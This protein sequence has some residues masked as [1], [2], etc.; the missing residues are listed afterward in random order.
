V[1]GAALKARKTTRAIYLGDVYYMDGIWV[2]YFLNQT[3]VWVYLDLYPF[4][5]ICVKD[6]F[7]NLS[8]LRSHLEH[9][10]SR[11]KIISTERISDYF[12]RR[13]ESPAEVIDYYQASL[14]EEILTPEAAPNRLYCIVYVHSFTD[15]QMERGYDGFKSVYEWLKFTVSELVAIHPNLTVILKAHPNFYSTGKHLDPQHA[16]LLDQKMWQFFLSNLPSGVT[17]IDKPISNASLLRLY[18]P[19]NTILISHHSNAIVEGAY[20]GFTSISSKAS[21]WSNLYNFSRVWDSKEEYRQFLRSIDPSSIIL[22]EKAESVR[23]FI[24]DVY[25]SPY[26]VVTGERSSW[27]VVSKFTGMPT[28]SIL[29]NPF[30]DPTTSTLQTQEI[31]VELS[32][33]I[34]ELNGLFE[35]S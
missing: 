9:A 35:L 30:V 3:R 12:L 31:I 25:L 33:R 1:L 6:S 28:A 18:K 23:K 17:V 7:R 19:E 8:R 34:D 20:L 13:L 29:N 5:L 16:T 24:S 11:Q 2:D 32:A 22:N 4:G 10:L 26:T 21:P 27:G 14:N 15:A